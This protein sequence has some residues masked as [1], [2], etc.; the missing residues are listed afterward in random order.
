MFRSYGGCIVGRA[1]PMEIL[2]IAVA[3]IFFVFTI[4]SLALWFIIQVKKQEL[5]ET[6]QKNEDIKQRNE[7]LI[8][9][10]ERII[11][12]AAEIFQENKRLKPYQQI[13]DVEQYAKRFLD[14]AKAEANSLIQEAK[15]KHDLAEAHTKQAEIE[16]NQTHARA[17]SH[18]QR[19]EH[20][21]KEIVLRAEEKSKSI[22]QE[23]SQY[24]EKI[25]SA[26]RE[27]EIIKSKAKVSADGIIQ[28]AKQN[29]EWQ[30]NSIV[31]TAQVKS[32]QIISSATVEAEEKNKKLNT[33]NESL[34][35]TIRAI[36]NKIE[37]YGVE[38]MMPG[39]GLLDNLA[40]D[41]GNTD[42]SNQYKKS[43]ANVKAIFNAGQSA[44][45][46]YKNPKQRSTVTAF[47]TDAF[48][49]KVEEILSRVK[50][51][52]YGKL[53]QEIRDAA[54]LINRAG[55]KFQ[56]A[57]L[58]NEYI[59]A[60]L[61][62]LKW[63]TVLHEVRLRDKEEQR[64][65]HEQIREERKIQ[66]EK[67][68]AE[69]EA[70]R[71]EKIR[72]KLQK[73]FGALLEKERKMSEKEKEF[74]ADLLASEKAKYVRDIADAEERIRLAE[75][76]KQ[77]A[78]SMAQQTKRGHVY[79]ISN[80]GSFGEGVYKIGMTRRLEPLD[81]IA[82]LSGASVPF[83]YDV[84]G[85]VDFEDC[86]AAEK[87]LHRVFV[88]G[89]VNKTTFRKEFFRASLSEIKEAIEQL[90]GVAHWTLHAEAEQYRQTQEIEK[91][92]QNDEAYRREWEERQ[93]RLGESMAS[94]WDDGDEEV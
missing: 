7:Y 76:K 41:Y 93:V 61:D 55:E 13:V 21:A 50:Y 46:D 36:K 68:E 17:Q 43:R 44:T 92:I 75:E 71:E 57:R 54:T 64:A 49:G 80:V 9:E 79:V 67:E 40:E 60:R 34:Q 42:A 66:K 72:E 3:I 88:M 89:Q 37:G 2:T 62:E 15:S 87:K 10:H 56:N 5:H 90:G 38:Y 78:L 27:A 4:I 12:K 85:M 81:R 53:A 65:L 20:Q 73:D 63:A 24:Q 52:N 86:P 39:I 29:A 26:N 77:R 47:I 6:N 84:H 94:L 59:I 8:A 33:T 16:A 69:Q 70:I 74:Y 1:I 48:N 11:A 58:T 30:A 14:N 25:D 51:D 28:D 31:R 45:N 18:V 32:E 22:I 82:E 23:A 19:A 91:R 35:K 83:P